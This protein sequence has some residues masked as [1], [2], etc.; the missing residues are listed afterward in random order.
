MN[1]YKDHPGLSTFCKML[2]NVEDKTDLWVV[3]ELGGK[4]IS[5]LLMQT[6]GQFYRGERIYEV[7]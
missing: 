3:Y 6:K 7:T 5:K 2:D 4:P 1:M